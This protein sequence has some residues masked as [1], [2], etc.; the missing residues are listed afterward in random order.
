MRDYGHRHYTVGKKVPEAVE[1]KYEAFLF[2]LAAMLFVFIYI[3]VA[4]Q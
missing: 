4:S 3:L 1:H 2:P